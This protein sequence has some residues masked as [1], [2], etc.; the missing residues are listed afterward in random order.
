MERTTGITPAT[1][2]TFPKPLHI[3]IESN[4]E[5][6]KGRKEEED[7]GAEEG[8]EGDAGEGEDGRE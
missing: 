3:E 8:E 1:A 6:E 7:D 5:S 2:T 4:D